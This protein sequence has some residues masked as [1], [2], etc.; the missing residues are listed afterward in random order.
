MQIESSPDGRAIVDKENARKVY[1][2][3]VAK[4]KTSLNTICA[5]PKL[6][7]KVEWVSEQG[8]FVEE[9]VW[10]DGSKVLGAS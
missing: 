4:I 7:S 1:A 6:Q 8:G 2:I 10:D 5:Q 9:E 3:I